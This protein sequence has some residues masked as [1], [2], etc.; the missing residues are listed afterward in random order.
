[1]PSRN[2]GQSTS[3]PAASPV[4]PLHVTALVQV[5]R[6][7]SCA[8]PANPSILQPSLHKGT[9]QP[10]R[11]PHTSALG[12]ISAR[13]AQLTAGPDEGLA[14]VAPPRATDTVIAGPTVPTR[15][16]KPP[17]AGC[18]QGGCGDVGPYSGQHHS[19]RGDTH[20]Y[21]MLSGLGQPT[22]LGWGLRKMVG[23]CPGWLL[24]P[25]HTEPARSCCVGSTEPVAICGRVLAAEG[26]A[27]R[28]TTALSCPRLTGAFSKG[29]EFPVPTSPQIPIPDGA[30]CLGRPAPQPPG[31]HAR[32]LTLAVA[33][34]VVLAALGDP[35]GGNAVPPAASFQRPPGRE[36]SSERF[37][38]G[39]RPGWPQWVVMAKQKSVP[40]QLVFEIVA[41]PGSPL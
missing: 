8:H 37:P 20:M 32:C 6:T 35:L 13:C 2:H 21:G 36:V 38:R 3:W 16:L 25:T 9:V 40:E 1:M 23:V 31:I 26:Q 12:P 24:L 17:R 18:R 27:M 41:A 30:L 39:G 14:A 28:L 22:T 19:H 34:I 5:F 33:A 11:A 4:H 7:D 29:R 15:R 10:P